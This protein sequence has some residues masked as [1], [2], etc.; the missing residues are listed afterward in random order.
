MTLSDLNAIAGLASSVGVA[1]SVVYLALQV[2]QAERSQRAVMQ[3]GRALRVSDANMR[4]VESGGW[5]IWM[6]GL[7]QPD[8]L[9]SDEIDQF[10]LLCRSSFISA[11]DSVLQYQA[12]LL[13]ERPYKSFVA[14]VKAL[15]ANSPAMRAAWRM[16]ASSFG[17]ELNVFMEEVLRAPVMA[18]TAD[19]GGRWR[20]AL[21]QEKEAVRALRHEATPT[22]AD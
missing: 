4:L 14:G 17:P 22:S 10:T 5:A 18:N 2:R 16:M 9:S 7:R 1:F 12:G 21:E 3:Q 20:D 6:K 15:L 13:D 19:W 8:D 11:E